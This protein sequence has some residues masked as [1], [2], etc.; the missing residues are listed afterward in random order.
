MSDEDKPEALRAFE[1][2]VGAG[3]L[4]GHLVA[5]LNVVNRRFNTGPNQSKWLLRWGDEEYTEETLT[6]GEIK[7]VEELSGLSWVAVH[8]MTSAASA[9]ALLQA[10]LEHRQNMTPAL[11][12]KT[13]NDMTTDAMVDIIDQYEV[14]A[15]KADSE[16]PEPTA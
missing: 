7:R 3:Q 16:S 1:L 11:A 13:V 4:D 8:P 12:A 15:P 5:A 6:M 2:A 10:F 14:E 9:A